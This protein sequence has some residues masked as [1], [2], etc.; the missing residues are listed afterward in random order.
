[1][2]ARGDGAAWP[3]LLTNHGERT[4]AGGLGAPGPPAKRIDAGPAAF[5][6]AR[7]EFARCD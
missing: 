4:K 1:M 3:L 7:L 2:G 6:A 5:D